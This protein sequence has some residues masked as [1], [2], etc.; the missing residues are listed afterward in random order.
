MK[1]VYKFVTGEIN[2]VEVSEEVGEVILSSRRQEHAD[3][4]RHRYH[5][6]VKLELADYYF[7]EFAYEV[8]AE[9]ELFIRMY[10]DERRRRFYDAFEQLTPVQ[11]RRVRMRAKGLTYKK[12]SEIEGCDVRAVFD[13]VQQARKIFK[14]LF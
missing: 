2:V 6:Q 11:K 3:N 12:I 1:I 8:S 10:E 4:E 13:S 9:E 14:K 7:G 5:S